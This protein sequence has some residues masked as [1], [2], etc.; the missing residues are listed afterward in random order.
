MTH[1]WR[2]EG[3]GVGKETTRGTAVDPAIWVQ[4]T[5]ADFE[6][7]V[8]KIIDESALG[9]LMNSSES[10]KTKQYAMWEITWILAST[11][12]G[13]FFLSLLG[14]V[15][16]SA[17]SSGAYSHEFTMDNVNAKQSLTISKKTPTQELRFALAM[18]EAFGLTANVGEQVFMRSALR[19]K[20]GQT[21]SLT[22]AYAEDNKFYAHMVTVKIADTVA[23]LDG[24][25]ALCLENI[26]LNLTQEL[27]DGFCFTS[28]VDLGDIYNKGFA[29]DGT[30][31][32]I[33]QDD[34]FEDLVRDETVKAMRIEIVDTSKT[35]GV[36]D[37]PTVK[38]DIAKVTFEDHDYEWGLNDVMRET[39]T[40]K[41]HYDLANA[42][43][44]NITV[45]NEQ[46]SY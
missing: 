19:A 43:D 32:K 42:S 2:L 36:S 20:A 37:N 26:E 15:V 27:E 44:L 3:Y 41:G 17:A 24:A 23:E 13:Y 18:I 31:G 39:V 12:V 30:F 5:E 7:N 1:I 34:T 38:V 11:S 16:S 22:K 28:G 9:V 46:A 29:I 21:S 40:F 33:V 4:Q 8:E 25:S 35:I 6:D 45:I 14:S 10:N